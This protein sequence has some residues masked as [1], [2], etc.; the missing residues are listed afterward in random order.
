MTE[1]A[2]HRHE[3]TQE[4]AAILEF[5]AGYPREIAEVMARVQWGEY[6]RSREAA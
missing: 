6:Q 1:S 4:R 5:E 3:W 2:L